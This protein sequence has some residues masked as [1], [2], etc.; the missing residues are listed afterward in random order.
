MAAIVAIKA[1]R[2]LKSADAVCRGSKAVT[3]LAYF[4]IA[5]LLVA[6]LTGAYAGDGGGSNPL[7]KI[8]LADLRVT[9][10][11]PL[12]S[13]SRRPPRAPLAAPPVISS[14]LPPPRVTQPQ[15]PALAL[16]GTIIGERDKIAVFLDETTKDT[17]R[18][19]V[20]QDH[21]GWTL[22]SVHGREVDLQ[23]DHRIATLSFEP[24]ADNQLSKKPPVDEKPPLD[25]VVSSTPE[26]EAY[27]AALRQRRG[28]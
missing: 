9:V 12:F 23:K 15:R 21:A 17:V 4:R 7:W 2:S 28:R 25:V 26:M 1:R 22:R 13:P 11:R 5:A 18:L 6:S 8:P 14:P 10:E 19:R 24:E 16:L 3:Q 27:R 20:G